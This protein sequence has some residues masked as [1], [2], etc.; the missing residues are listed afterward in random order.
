MQTRSSLATSDAGAQSPMAVGFVRQR[1]SGHGGQAAVGSQEA[2]D[3]DVAIR[4]EAGQDVAILRQATAIREAAEE[5]TAHLRAVIV[6]LSEQ[7]GQTSAF[8]MENLASHGLATMPAPETAPARPAGPGTRPGAPAGRPAGLTGPRTR[9]DAPARP[10]TAPAKKEG[11]RGRQVRAMR[12]ASAATATLFAF[13]V[14]TAAAE[15]SHFGLK[16]F[17]FRSTGTGET[18]PNPGTDQQ[19][20]AQE[21]AAAKAAAAKPAAAKAH[22]PGR[23]S[24]KK[25]SGS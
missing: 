16:F 25:T 11:A 14:I 7:L 2:F 6:S 15:V 17:V 24:A 4:Q 21:A 23:H 20:L 5:E 8:L 3:Q 9:P 12:I 10:R 1:V 13:A 19:F 22:T 18:G